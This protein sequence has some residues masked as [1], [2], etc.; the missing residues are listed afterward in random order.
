V[1][2]ED[3]L[4]TLAAGRAGFI[5][6]SVAAQPLKRGRVIVDFVIRGKSRI[7]DVKSGIRR[8][9]APPRAEGVVLPESRR[10][11]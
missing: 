4:N 2:W 1:S 3:A 11:P 8:L 9:G 6:S 7:A 10:L 5:D